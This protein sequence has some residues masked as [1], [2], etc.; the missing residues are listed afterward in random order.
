MESF[1]GSHRS[2]QPDG[3]GPA[4]APAS[5]Q[6]PQTREELNT[7]NKSSTSVESSYLTPHASL[8]GGRIFTPMK[9][10]RIPA[11]ASQPV[12]QSPS[13]LVVVLGGSPRQQA[14]SPGSRARNEDESNL[15]ASD[16]YPRSTGRPVGRP[17]ASLKKALAP[18]KREA[19]VSSSVGMPAARASS[20]SSEALPAK[21]RGRPFGWKPGMGPYSVMNQLP[22]DGRPAA[23]RPPK[24]LASGAPGGMRKRKGRPPKAG[25]GPPR[26]IYERLRPKYITFLCEWEGCPAELQNLET[27]R[28]HILAVHGQEEACRWAKC[29]HNPSPTH[30][31]SRQDLQEHVES[32]HLV[33]FAWHAGDGPRNTSSEAETPHTQGGTGA[34]PAYLFDSEGN[35]ITPSALHQE[36]EDEE[37][38]KA[39][40]KRLR[41]ILL[42]R[43]RNAPEEEEE[44]ESSTSLDED[45][46][47]IFNKR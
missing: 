25:T 3:Q 35:Q 34:L 10:Q 36:F 42:Q 12:A 4:R 9:P 15:V 14:Q 19:S 18:V 8:Q 16:L 24:K 47:S 41:R 21:K 45:H 27:L 17:V 43:D 30:L 32:V 5:F 37:E 38:R 44:E 1:V 26:L 13:H 22:L 29:A 23:P 31:P 28:R 46:E 7:S 20:K 6:E 11:P 33:P 39:R 40:R 2:F